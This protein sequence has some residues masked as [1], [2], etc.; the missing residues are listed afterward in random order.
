MLRDVSESALSLV[1]FDGGH[2]DQAVVLGDDHS[3]QSID[4][5]H[6]LVFFVVEGPL[7]V[8]DLLL[9]VFGAYFLVKLVGLGRGREALFLEYFLG[10]FSELSQ[11]IHNLCLFFDL[12]LK[13]RTR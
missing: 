9:D 13:T 7:V 12:K 2:E 1:A 3:L 11:K 5:V 10:F 6:H 4:L 8:L